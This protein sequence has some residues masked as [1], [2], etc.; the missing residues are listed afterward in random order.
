MGYAISFRSPTRAHAGND[1]PVA[2]LAKDLEKR[3]N[4]IAMFSADNETFIKKMFFEYAFGKRRKADAEA[5]IRERWQAYI[6]DEEHG[7]KTDAA[8]AEGRQSF[9]DTGDY[10]GSLIPEIIE[11]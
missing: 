11:E 8:A 1:E 9:V 4:I 10:F 5:R 7:I 3:F 2:D 6:I